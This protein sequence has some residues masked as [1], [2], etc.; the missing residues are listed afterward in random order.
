MIFNAIQIVMFDN[1]S[2]IDKLVNK[3]KAAICVISV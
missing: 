1:V 2:F 3:R